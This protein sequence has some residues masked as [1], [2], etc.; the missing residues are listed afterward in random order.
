MTDAPSSIALRPRRTGQSQLLEQLL[1]PVPFAFAASMFANFLV[2]LHGDDHLFMIGSFNLHGADIATAFCAIALLVSLPRMGRINA[3]KMCVFVFGAVA[4]FTLLRGVMS[5]SFRAFYV[6]RTRAVTLA[7]LLYV[8]F[9]GRKLYPITKIEPLFIFFV[10]L[11]VC[12]FVLR[13][14][15]GSALFLFHDS[16][17]YLDRQWLD[18]RAL[19]SDA[20]LFMDFM[21][22]YFANKLFRREDRGN[23]SSIN[24]RPSQALSLSSMPPKMH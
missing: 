16:T 4:V 18:L 14:L 9:S 15:F 7:F 17:A 20:V 12:L 3:L 2:D 8:A 13:T 6:F 21:L 22:I 19:S 5:D 10:G 24:W 11:Y 23:R 1:H